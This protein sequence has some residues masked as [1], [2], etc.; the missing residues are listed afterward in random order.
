M[1]MWNA[2][3]Q[4]V[5]SVVLP[6]DVGGTKELA[7]LRNEL[8][9]SLLIYVV[10]I[11]LIA[12]VPGVYMSF[13]QGMPVLG[14]CD[15][16]AFFLML[17]VMVKRGLD[18]R[19]RKA[20]V[21]MVFYF[22]SIV[23][24]YYVS[25]PGSGM[26]Y[27]LALTVITS[28]V[29]SSKAAYLSAAA[30]TLVCLGFA[31]LLYAGIA[32]PIAADYTP[33]VWITISSNLVTLSFILA[34]CSNLLI[35]GLEKTIEDRNISQANLASV[36]EN[37][38]AS[39]YSLD[40]EFRYITFNRTLKEQLKK[41]YGLEITA[42]D[43]VFEFLERTEPEE[44]RE[45]QR[46]YEEALTGKVLKF[47]KE[48]HVGD[49]HSITSF[50]IFPIV[51]KKKVIGLSCFVTDVTALKHTQRQLERTQ[52]ELEE[53][54]EQRTR[55][56][57]QKTTG[58]L[59][60]INYAK[61]IQTGVFARQ[62]QVAELFPR[63]FVLARPRDILSGDFFWCHKNRD[64][65]FIVLAD[66][67]GHGVSGALMSIIGN[68][69]LD[70]IIVDE[71]IENPTEIM[72]RLDVRLREAIKGDG[73]EVIDGMDMTLCMVDNSFNELYFTG[74]RQAL[75]LAENGTVKQLPSSPYSI[76][77]G[78]QG[79]KKEFTT[80]RIPIVPGQRI[81]LT[82]KGYYAQFGGPDDKKFMRGRF[83][84][85]LQSIQGNTMAEQQEL[86]LTTLEEWQGDRDSV[87]DV[88]VV[89]IEL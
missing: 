55:E 61:R 37:T 32:V 25:R 72:Q 38:D 45:W 47:E 18:I 12:L 46:V 41:A 88:L 67:T 51:E 70:Q 60:S 57:K 15:L 42:G 50:S 26:L 22:L 3:K 11:S 27:L 79:V 77:A 73:N 19:H 43:R 82:S 80:R 31:A 86:L 16:T 20:I 5:R 83:N 6:V 13:K 52:I 8:F 87:D 68:N 34:V 7:Q 30:N 63:S 49:L 69:L 9:C 71:H 59:E 36:I 62:S 39:I 65:K 76:S 81:Y 4:Y 2:Y 17:M 23:L 53:R 54:V 44:A 48:F 14:I 85:T 58:I 40:R 21:I 10:P 28:M 74:A 84:R 66:C 64:R 89:G 24:L 33:A 78:M 75:F 1:R 35:E 56:L 29:Y